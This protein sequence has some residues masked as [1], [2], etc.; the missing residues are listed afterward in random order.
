MPLRCNQC[1]AAQDS[2][3][4]TWIWCVHETMK[5]TELQARS[6]AILNIY[7]I[8]VQIPGFLPQSKDIQVRWIW[9]TK[10]PVGT[11]ASVNECMF[12]CY[13]CDGLTGHM[14]RVFPWLQHKTQGASI[15]ATLQRTSSVENGWIDGCM[16]FKSQSCV[17][18][19]A[20]LWF[21]SKRSHCFQPVCTVPCVIKNQNN[22]SIMLCVKM[23][24][25]SINDFSSYALTMSNN[26]CHLDSTY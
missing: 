24:A 22:R 1:G 4:R 16:E 17:K 14:S 10:L 13:P 11:S 20:I 23:I 7:H 5:G 9:D 19:I 8:G 21:V 2:V 3:W 18:M 15:T 12:V 25:S 6:A 26:G